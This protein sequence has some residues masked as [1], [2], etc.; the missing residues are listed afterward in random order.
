MVEPGGISY[1]VGYET[2]LLLCFFLQLF[3]PSILNSVD[4]W[5][6]MPCNVLGIELADIKGNL[7]LGVFTD[8]EVQWQLFRPPKKNKTTK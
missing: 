6:K 2:D 7:V 1:L 5:R 8:E 3:L 4:F